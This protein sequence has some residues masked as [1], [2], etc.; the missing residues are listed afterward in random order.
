M[1]H[2]ADVCSVIVQECILYYGLGLPARS[3]RLSPSL[4]GPARLILQL[5]ILMSTCFATV[6]APG[7]LPAII[8]G[9]LPIF[10]MVVTAIT[11]KGFAALSRTMFLGASVERFDG[12][13]S[14]RRPTFH[15]FPSRV[16]ANNTFHL[17]PWCWCFGCGLPGLPGICV[18]L[19]QS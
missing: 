18:L 9:V 10:A 17:K 11:V 3:V 15:W 5:S 7:A 4:S 2:C 13:V 16:A 14:I 1:E 12:L 8:V 19:L 6:A